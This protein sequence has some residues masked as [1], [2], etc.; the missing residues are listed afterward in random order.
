MYTW[1]F[2]FFLNYSG[3]MFSCGSL[4]TWTCPK[5]HSFPQCHK[6][7]PQKCPDC[8]LDELLKYNTSIN[9]DLSIKGKYPLPLE[10]QGFNSKI[11]PFEKYSQR[12]IQSQSQSLYNFDVWSRQQDPM[13][14]PLFKPLVIPCFI[15]LKE[16]MQDLQAFEPRFIIILF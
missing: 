5:N 3:K 16:D 12:F 9:E 15:P 6:G 4:T 13:R 7:T 2:L 14:R 8:S 1:T 11:L 10:L